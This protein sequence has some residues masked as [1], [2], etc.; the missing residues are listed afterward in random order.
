M[1]EQ[2]KNP[3]II[4]RFVFPSHRVAVSSSTIFLLGFGLVYWILLIFSL[5]VLTEC[6]YGIVWLSGWFE[7]RSAFQ[8]LFVAIGL[9][10]VS[11]CL[12][13][14]T[15]RCA[16]SFET[17]AQ[18][19]FILGLLLAA[20]AQKAHFFP[21]GTPS[22]AHFDKVMQVISP[23]SLRLVEAQD[24]VMRFD[25][26]WRYDYPKPPFSTWPEPP[27]WDKTLNKPLSEIFTSKDAPLYKEYVSLQACYTNYQEAEQQYVKDVEALDEYWAGFKEW[28]ALNRWRYGE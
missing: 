23:S 27:R 25:E 18:F 24:F 2:K 11:W 19:V 5:T 14:F 21:Y 10:A 9:I 22:Q 26:D 8:W 1:A 6:G 16:N 17:A 4:G 15:L 3:K 28:Y 12:R 20:L 7:F 13:L